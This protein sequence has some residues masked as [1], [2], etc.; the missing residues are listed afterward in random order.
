M[1]FE[2]F[3]LHLELVYVLSG[4]AV[5]FIVGMTGVGGG[6]GRRHRGEQ[7][8]ADLADPKDPGSAVGPRD[9]ATTKARRREEFDRRRKYEF[10]G[11][12]SAAADARQQG[13]SPPSRCWA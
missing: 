11:H 10:V 8:S 6:M 5:G 2:L 12:S 1:Q 3:G 13:C 9:R 4:L 7:R